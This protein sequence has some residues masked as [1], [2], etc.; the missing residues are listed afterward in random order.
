MPTDLETD[1]III[2]AGHNGLTC[3]AYLAAAGKSVRVLEARDIVG[4]AAVTEEFHPGFRNSTASY[5]VSLLNAKVIA[6]LDLYRHG[7]TFVRR[8]IS[9]FWPLGNKPGEYLKLTFDS[10]RNK[11]EFARL[12]ENDAEA[13]E[14]YTTDIET[15]ADL[16]RDIIL[17]TPPNLGGGISDMWASI[18]LGNKFRKLNNT[19]QALVFDLFTVSAEDFLRRYFEHPAIIGAFAFDGIVG[20]YAAPST[21]GT[22]YVLLHH[23]FGELNGVK[24]EW[25]HAIGGMGA[26][27]SAMAAVGRASGVDIVL[28]AR[29][30]S[31]ETQDGTVRGVHLEDGRVFRAKTIV[32]N[33]NP[34]HLTRDL[35]SDAD[36]PPEGEI[37]RQKM[38]HYQCGSASFRMNLALSGL[39]DFLCQPGTA[40]EEHH[41]SGIIIGPS[42]G[43]LEQAFL[44]ARQF[45]WS[46]KPVIEMLIPSTI[47]GTLAPAGS[48]VMSLFCQHFAPEL[49]NGKSWD[50]QRDDA[51]ETIIS[52]IET[53]APNIRELIV[54]QQVHSPLDLERKFGL[55][56]GDIFH[57]KLSLNQMFSARPQL[58]AANYRLP[59]KGLYLCGSGAHPGGGVTGVPGHNCAREILKDLR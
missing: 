34:V 22:A 31:L 18:K 52:T 44:D 30:A 36:L 58:G 13:Y 43:Y 17:E 38:T 45:G 15:A 56:R 1:V 2:G 20:N 8:E 3:A 14:R 35:L 49:A 39:P 53:Y 21:P 16:L 51:V 41:K 33:A 23:A 24:G 59:I 26:I 19:A 12:S 37:F 25:G 10:A 4:G 27:T 40:P 32:S 46:K 29:V 28:N 11:E 50:D 9:N 47:D 55:E 42:V 48:H 57:G 6:D 7:L 54:G 5:T